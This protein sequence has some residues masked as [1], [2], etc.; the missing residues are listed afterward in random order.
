MTPKSFAYRLIRGNEAPQD[1]KSSKW[2]K[3]QN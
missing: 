3:Q 2:F 1:T